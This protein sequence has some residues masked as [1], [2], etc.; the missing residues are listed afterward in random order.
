ME[1]IA[2]GKPYSGTYR[3]EGIKFTY[4]RGF[5]LNIFLKNLSTEEIMDIKKGEYNFGIT[6]IDG[7]MYFTCSFG[8]SINISDAPFHFGLYP[9]DRAKDLPTVI[10]EGQGLALNITAVDSCSG[11]VKALRLIGLSTEFSREL[12]DISLSQ[13]R[14]MVE[15]EAY[16]RQ[17]MD[18]QNRYSSEDLYEMSLVRCSGNST[19]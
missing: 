13:S 18:S 9:E 6:M 16:A 3:Q 15:N 8:E 4:N 17:L 12:I 19:K 7:V 11:I 10:A 2:V 1:K 14:L 5:N